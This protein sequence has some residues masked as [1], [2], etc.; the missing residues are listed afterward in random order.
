MGTEYAIR[1]VIGIINNYRERFSKEDVDNILGT[2]HEWLDLIT[3]SNRTEEE[4][5]RLEYIKVGLSSCVNKMDFSA[6][7][8]LESYAEFSKCMKLL[9]QTIG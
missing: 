1:F 2:L 8:E 9:G 5:R 7:N 3:T 4:E 6:L